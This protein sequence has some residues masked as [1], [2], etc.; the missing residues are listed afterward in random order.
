MK[1]N[2]LTNE[3]KN[4]HAEIAEALN[5]VV[6]LGIGNT[7][8]QKELMNAKGMLLR[9][10]Q[11]EDT[12]LYPKLAQAAQ[13]DDKLKRSLNSFARDMNEISKVALNFFDKYQ[14]GGNGIEFARDFGHLFSVMSMRIRKEETYLY[15]L[16]DNLRN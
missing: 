14:E 16:Y 3:L 10:L 8:G 15:E 12:F 6:K 5:K 1:N 13:N 4:E 7:K 11:K 2:S 9:H